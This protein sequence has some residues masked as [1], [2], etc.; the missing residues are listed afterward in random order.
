MKERP[1]GT[2]LLAGLEDAIIETDGEVTVYDYERCLELLADEPRDYEG[3]VDFFHYN[4]LPTRDALF[5]NSVI[6][7]GWDDVED[8]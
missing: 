6:F 8:S 2:I 5:P 3:A 4:T 7:R 1:D